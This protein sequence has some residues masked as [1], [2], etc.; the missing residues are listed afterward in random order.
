[1]INKY[2]LNEETYNFIN[3]KDEVIS[4]MKPSQE[5]LY[6]WYNQHTNKFNDINSIKELESG[7][8]EI[9]TNTSC[10]L[11]GKKGGLTESL[12]KY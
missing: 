7:E 10:F 1:M 12:K 5:K 6:N 2:I 3:K 11:I 4:K 9:V 8:I